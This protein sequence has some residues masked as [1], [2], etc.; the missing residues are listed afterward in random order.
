MICANPLNTEPTF[1]VTKDRSRSFKSCQFH[2]IQLF[3][4]SHEDWSCR[5]SSHLRSPNSTCVRIHTLNPELLAI[6]LRSPEYLTTLRSGDWNVIDGIWLSVALFFKKGIFLR[7]RCGSDLIDDLL[8]ECEAAGLPFFFIGG[9]PE[10]LA[11]A[12]ANIRERHPKL[13]CDGFSPTFSRDAKFPDQSELEARLRAVKPAIVAVCLGSPKQEDWMRTNVTF[14]DNCGVRIVAGLGGTVDFLSGMIPRAPLWV[15]RIG[16]E[17]LY[18]A[19][20]EPFRFKR[21]WMALPALFKSE[22]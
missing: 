12:C 16:M 10:R 2:G 4:E 7:R 15:R 5:I 22:K 14:L 17:W 6:G 1:S 3:E 9:T 21:Y 19:W 13:A 8:I 11:A 20:N 18:R